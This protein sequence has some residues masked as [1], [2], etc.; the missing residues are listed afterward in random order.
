MAKEAIVALSVTRSPRGL[1][2]SIRLL[3]VPSE[4]SWNDF[5][6][7][8][9]ST[10]GVRNS[11]DDQFKWSAGFVAFKD[12]NDSRRFLEK[13]LRARDAL[14]FASS[15]IRVPFATLFQSIKS[16]Q[17]LVRALS[18][19]TART[20]ASEARDVAHFQ[21]IGKTI[22]GWS[23]FTQSEHFVLAF[24]RSSD[25]AFAYRHAGEILAGRTLD[26][27]DSRQ[28]FNAEVKL[29]KGIANFHFQFER[30]ALS[31]NR[32]V[33][34]IG[35]NGVGKTAS[36]MAISKSLLGAQKRGVRLS[37]SPS[38]NQIL[39]F[40]HSSNV[41]RFKLKRGHPR[42]A[43]QLVF[44]LDP[45]NA[46]SSAL[47]SLFA[48]IA[49]ESGTGDNP[50]HK[51]LEV[52]KTE[53]HGLA[54]QIPVRP[55]DDSAQRIFGGRSYVPFES[56]GRGGEQ[57][58]LERVGRIDERRKPVFVGA[59]MKPRQLSLGQNVFVHFVL[60]AI[61]EGGPAS[62]F[63]IDELENFLHPNLISKFVRILHT[64]L[65]Q[66]KSI[67]ILSTHSPYVVREV[68]SSQVHV[69]Q[70]DPQGGVIVE[71]PR[72]QSFGA[73]ISQISDDIFDDDLPRHLYLELMKRLPRERIAVGQ[74]IDGLR[75]EVSLD[76]V[77]RLREIYDQGIDPDDE[78]QVL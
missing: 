74:L 2:S 36:L 20:V 45:K 16:Y 14:Y 12:E 63:L 1:P 5:A 46:G 78:D 13:E 15:E 11:A 23:D 41:A 57:A 30:S 10:V 64:V 6:Y 19:E 72:M 34:L 37:N 48:Q 65:A 32:I 18:A 26:A 7:R 58:R 4:S 52:F 35:R 25:A 55:S 21:A 77:M 50:M 60:R 33:V 40:A 51:L 38:F 9:N 73:N 56:F 76:A 59:D 3:I 67:A 62:A 24:M 47:S 68:S 75:S 29:G 49:R 69:L 53:F 61:A 17:L 22:E 44:S 70:L 71:R 66:T 54:P 28:N 42:A 39:V 27:Q 31:D 8:A 43:S